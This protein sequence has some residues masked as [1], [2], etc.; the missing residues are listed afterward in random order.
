MPDKLI[1]VEGINDLDLLERANALQAIANLPT[2]ALKNMASLASNDK[3]KAYLTDNIKFATLKK[4][5]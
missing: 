1:K 2:K 4:F 5:L 3:A